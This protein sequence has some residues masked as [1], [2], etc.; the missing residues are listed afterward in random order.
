MTTRMTMA[1]VLAT[2]QRTGTRTAISC[3]AARIQTISRRA[4]NRARR[5]DEDVE[6]DC[7]RREREDPEPA[8]PAPD[9]EQALHQPDQEGEAQPSAR[10][11]RAAGV[12]RPA[13]I[14]GEV[15]TRATL[16]DGCGDPDT[17]SATQSA[18]RRAGL[19]TRL[20]EPVNGRPGAAHVRPE[21]AGGAKAR[22]KRRGSGRLG[23]VVRRQSCEVPRPAHP[24][25][26]R[27]ARPSSRESRGRRRAHR[28]AHRP[29]PSSPSRARAEGRVPAR[30][31]GAAR[32]ASGGHPCPR[33]ASGPARGR[34]GRR[35]RG[36]RRER[37]TVSARPA[38][39][40]PRW[41]AEAPRPRR[42]SRL[43]GLPRPGSPS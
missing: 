25:K 9:H 36:R 40:A 4:W 17:A 38:A 1:R 8:E 37:A 42:R 20:E 24:G 18:R 14:T 21:G 35:R 10:A 30:S 33:P 28:S 39:G 26:A 23:K 41:P 11:A 12:L 31:P 6:G 43:P 22:D 27:G 2:S 32:A 16:P 29:R 34:T 7:D 19:P 3:D 15:V 5:R 13:S